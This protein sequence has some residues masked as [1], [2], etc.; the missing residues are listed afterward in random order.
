[1]SKSAHW[2]LTAEFHLGN[3]RDRITDTLMWEFERGLAFNFI[4]VVM[5]CGIAAYFFAPSEPVMLVLAVTVAVLLYSLLRF[6][7]HGTLYYVV[8]AL[9]VFATGMLAANVSVLRSY[10]PQIERQT[11]TTLSG[12]ILSVDQ[13]RRG[14][15]RMILRPTDIEGIPQQSIPRKLRI[16]SSARDLS[17]MP[18]QIVQGLVRLQPV[19]GPVHPDSY[20]FSFHA[21][22]AGIGGS[23]FF[24]GKPTIL[25]QNPDL[26]V[27]EHLTVFVNSL[28]DKIEMRVVNAIPGTGGDV[29]VAL[30]TG[31]KSRIPE[32]VSQSLRTTGL[33]HILAISGLHMALVTL[34]IIAVVR[35]ACALLPNLCLNYPVKKWAVCAGFLGATL[36]LFLSGA[37]IATQR[38]WIMISVMLLAVLLDKRAI[39]MRS[40]AVSA[41]LILLI[42]PQSLFAPGFQMSFAA[43]AALVS[44]YEYLTARKKSKHQDSYLIS[45]PTWFH[46]FSGSVIGYVSGLI[47]TSLIAGSATAFVAAWHF[48]QIAPL[49]LLANAL[50]MPIVGFLVMPFALLS[51][52]LMPYGLEALTLM[53][54]EVGIN[55][56]IRISRAVESISPSGITG[57]MPFFS[58]CIFGFALTLL[59]VFRSRLRFLA[60]TPVILALPLMNYPTKPHILVSE[61][62]RAIAV[63]DRSGNLALVYP[64]RNRFV[65]NIWA[66]AWAGG[67]IAPL[68]L[69]DDQCNKDRCIIVLPTSQIL[70]VV[71]DPQLLNASCLRADILI[72][73]RLWW[74]RCPQRQPALTLNRQ[75]FE[76]Y[77]SH[78]IHIQKLSLEPSSSYEITVQTGLAKSRRPWSR[79]VG[80]YDPPNDTVE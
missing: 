10:S 79:D 53:P 67:D 74:V 40:V 26:T 4:P 41:T 24:M 71:Y 1:L 16:S 78:A 22:F 48:H 6:L 23:G 63:A 9:L 59:T 70:H 65:T 66:K 54:V 44:G 47:M 5:A 52:L 18:G 28:R 19:A 25:H 3:F 61:N 7:T 11:T 80:L 21:W 36:Y 58:L 55:S 8:A 42:S 31:D 30:I 73:P 17:V 12:V 27:F 72:A 75:S 69:S 35:F 32:D 20:N 46:R 68:N 77:G 29:A 38:A 76:Q 60:I 56:V 43:V 13:N 2:R 62:G 37:G 45:R 50:A 33:A 39:T 64:R 57:N 15:P 34:T 14:L 49:G 51:M